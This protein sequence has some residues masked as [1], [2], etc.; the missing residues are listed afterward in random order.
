ML[1]NKSYKSFVLCHINKIVRVIIPFGEAESFSLLAAETNPLGWTRL[2]S[3]KLSSESWLSVKRGFNLHVAWFIIAL[4]LSAPFIKS[5]LRLLDSMG[6][7]KWS[8][9]FSVSDKRPLF[10]A[11]SPNTSINVD[12]MRSAD[13]G[14][15][16]ATLSASFLGVSNSFVDFERSFDDEPRSGG[17]LTIIVSISSLFSLSD[18]DSKLEVSCDCGGVLEGAGFKETSC[19]I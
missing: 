19:S 3:R 8:L 18:A 14:W 15:K 13:W 12:D 10:S 11:S 1:F 5:F 7:S 9:P 17:E 16:G 6:E 2:K 4:S